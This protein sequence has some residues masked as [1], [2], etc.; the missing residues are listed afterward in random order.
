[1][2]V[3]YKGVSNMPE[4]VVRGQSL[5]KIRLECA[6]EWS[7]HPEELKIEVLEK[8]TFFSRQ[9]KVQVSLSN[10][11]KEHTLVNRDLPLLRV[12]DNIQETVPEIPSEDLDL[13]Q[14]ETSSTA[15]WEDNRYI[16]K[17]GDGLT[18]IIPC[19]SGEVL[20]NGVIQE[21]PFFYVK[22]DIIEFRP[23]LEPGKLNWVLD[24]YFEGLSV[25]AK[26]IHSEPGTYVLPEKFDAM[27]S[28]DL[29]KY[30]EWH[31]LPSEGDFWDEAHLEKDLEQLRIVHGRQPQAWLNIL[32]VAGRGEVVIAEAT[33]PIAPQAAKLEDFVGVP[34]PLD[35]SEE[36]RIDFFAS[37]IVLVKEG[38]VLARKIPSIPGVPGK[39]VFGRELPTA[40]V[41][42]FQFRVK[43][44]VRLS[45]DGLEVLAT[46]DG[47][48]IRIDETTYMIESV[49]VLNR[50][51]DLETGSIEFP[52]DVYVN[53]NVQDSLH[54]YAGGK[55]EIKGAVSRAE[56][57][58]DKGINVKQNVIGGKLIVGH[59]YVIRAEILR[60][61]NSLSEELE[62]CL[63]QT[64]ELLKAPEAV[65]LKPGQGLKLVIE[66]YF[67][68]LP[69]IA[70]RTESYLLANK[71]DLV[72]QE[73][74]ISVRTA[75]HFLVGLGPLDLQAYPFLMR[76]NQVLKQ[77]TVSIALDIPEKLNCIVN[78]IQGATIES[79]GA[80]ECKN[81]AYN[82]LIRADG[83]LKIEGVCRGGKIIAGG[84]VS[85][86]ELGGSGVSTTFVQI[87]G[88]KQLNVTY[89]HPNVTIRVDKEIIN[90][91]EA[92]K[93]LVIYRERGIVQIEKL[94]V[95]PL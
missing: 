26:V 63:K 89:C 11:P 10:D 80:F 31:D 47:Q 71:D 52:G 50:D 77:F 92:Y 22:G 41:R 76:V 84:N 54:I 38:A 69:K 40:T 5:E 51:V 78:Y 30:I 19:Q 72:K 55:V 68:D 25:I 44:N 67:P 49:F 36:Q 2:G 39:D 7:C 95:N 94:R 60:L 13:K 58:A 88:S 8:P 24:V 12:G 32:N 33:L 86:N 21:K 62:N 3:L 17:P 20:C 16:I 45:D 27:A 65:R 81:S 91:D 64:A 14:V 42:E 73:L 74:I 18:K 82:S 9:W 28:L 15:S 37:K 85:I 93:Q 59:K 1:M 87:S 57:R 75:R 66:R 4:K 70:T 53:G 48:P 46:C 79:G 61:L 56:I 90:I 43:K 23:F 34:R 29:A 83:D 6:Q 35:D